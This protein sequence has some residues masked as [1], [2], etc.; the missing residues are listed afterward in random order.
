MTSYRAR[1]NRTAL[2]TTLGI[3]VA[4]ANLVGAFALAIR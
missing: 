1:R 2:L 3:M 4:L